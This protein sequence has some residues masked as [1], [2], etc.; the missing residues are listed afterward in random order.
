MSEILK[1]IKSKTIKKI[2]VDMSRY[3][4]WYVD[5]GNYV[6]NFLVSAKL[7]GGFEGRLIWQLAGEE[8]TGKT[9]IWVQTMQIFLRENPDAVG[10]VYAT[11]NDF[12]SVE[13]L[14]KEFGERFI[15]I[16]GNDIHQVQTNML[17]VY[18]DIEDINANEND[19]RTM[20]VI[21]S[22]GFLASASYTEKAESGK[23]SGMDLTSTKQKNELAS[24]LIYKP[25]LTNS[26]LFITNHVYIP[27]EMYAKSVTSGGMKLKYAAN[28]TIVLSKKS[29]DKAERSEK[30]IVKIELRKGRFPSKENSIVEIPMEYHKG[31]LT[32]YGGLF[33]FAYECGAITSTTKGWY[34]WKDILD[35]KF[36]AKDVHEN[37]EKFFTND[38]L[39][40]I[41]TEA[42]PIFC[43]TDSKE[44]FTYNEFED[45]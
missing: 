25:V 22:W 43:Y 44:T 27:P 12:K 21:D 5:T 9:R 17:N 23:Q 35:K 11:E 19:L 1:A 2:A 7:R 18:K 30:T 20:V 31:G 3:E 13:C 39:D 29:A 8:A 37:P 41:E 42:I 36:R 16:P 4:P 14:R 32:R 6:L 28:G 38:R 40:L 45:E 24:S 15:Y 10:I 33:K 34:S 26:V